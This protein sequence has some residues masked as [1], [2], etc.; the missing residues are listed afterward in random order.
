MPKNNKMYDQRLNIK[1]SISISSIITMYYLEFVA[2]YRSDHDKHPFWEFVYVDNGHVIVTADDSTRTLNKGEIILH[3][4]NETHSV[5][6]DGITPAN[7]FIMSFVTNSGA[8]KFFNNRIITVPNS[9]Q[10]LLAA[11]VDEMQNAYG[12]NPGLIRCHPAEPFGIEQAIKNYTELFL[13]LLRR[14]VE[15]DKPKNSYINIV[16]KNSSKNN[17]L[18]SQVIDALENNIYG[19]ISIDELCRI[20]N[21]GKSQLCYIFKKSTG[22]TIIQYFNELK[23]DEAKF[24]MRTLR[25]SISQISD[26]LGFSSPQ[27]FIRLFKKTTSM[28][29]SDYKK[30]I[31]F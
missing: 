11:I 29:P 13:I 3:K 18:V 16:Y 21:Y 15:N 20:T 27:H 2:D 4:P 17:Q 24:L 14:N 23:I 6:C 31:T 19:N 22:K 25:L 8:M 7:I 1:T 10:G 30:S 28:T 9:L 12:K 5:K 26:R